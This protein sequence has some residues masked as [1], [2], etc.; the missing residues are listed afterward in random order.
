MVKNYKPL[1]NI[2]FPIGINHGNE[3]PYCFN[4]FL[5]DFVSE[6]INLSGKDIIVNEKKNT[7][8]N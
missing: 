7:F 6:T 8:S 3:K 4:N 1:N 2:V 5:E